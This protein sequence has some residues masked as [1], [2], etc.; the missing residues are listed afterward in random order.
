[1][2]GGEQQQRESFAFPVQNGE[3]LPFSVKIEQTAKGARVSVHAYGR[4][5]LDAVAT[6]VE[7]YGDVQKR[8]AKDGHTIAPAEVK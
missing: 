1:M 3:A 5:A 2:S 7:M 4:T 8:L 6:A